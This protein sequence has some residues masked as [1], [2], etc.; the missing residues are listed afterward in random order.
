M[1]DP[2]WLGLGGLVASTLSALAAYLAIR[3]NII[4]RRISNKVQITVKGC[5]INLSRRKIINSINL[6]ND[7]DEFTMKPFIINIGLGPALNFVYSW[8]FDYLKHLNMN[9]IKNIGNENKTPTKQYIKI[10]D[11]KNYFFE[12]SNEINSEFIHILGNG[13]TA[14]FH[15]PKKNNEIDYILPWSVS[16]SEV[17]LKLPNLIPILLAHYLTKYSKASIGM[18]LPITGPTLI[19]CYEDI[20]GVKIKE[21]FTSSFVCTR[22]SI[23]GDTFEAGFSLTFSP[24]LS[25]TS[26]VI[27]RIRKSYVDFMNEHDYNKNK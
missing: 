8:D 23:K 6:I 27:Q 3:Q 10:I 11:S 16:K 13:K 22:T 9:E 7:K 26:Q 4:Q 1:A 20:T 25:R 21:V 18:F 5:E 24:R 17:P 14:W 19:L 15:H 12:Y 2:A